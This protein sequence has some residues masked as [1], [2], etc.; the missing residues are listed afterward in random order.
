MTADGEANDPVIENN[1]ARFVVG[2]TG[3][4]PLLHVTNT[5][6][7]GLTTLLRD[8]GLDVTAVA[9][10]E[11]EAGAIQLANASGVILENVAA[12]D[13]PA[14]WTD[15]LAGLVED[16]GTGLWMTGG[17]QGFGPGGWF[18]SAIDPLLP[19]SMELRQEHR[20][21][22]LAI[23][24]ALDRSGSMA[25]TVAGGKQKMDL[26]NLGTAQVLELLSPMDE[27]GV[28]AVDSSAHTIADLAP[29]ADKAKL[30]NDILRIESMGG[31][32]YVFQALQASAEMLADAKAGTRH[33]V[34]FADAA[35][36]EEPGAYVALLAQCR[37]ANI[38]C[39]V[40]GLGR[41]TDS[42]AAFLRDVAAKGGGRIFFTED[43]R[44]LPAL[45]AQDTFAVARSAFVDEPTPL[46]ATAALAPLLGASAPP[47]GPPDAG[48]FGLT[49]LRPEATPA[50]LTA[51]EFRAP[52]VATWSAGLGRAAAFTGEADGETTGSLRGWP[53]YGDLLASLARFTAG[54]D[55]AAAGPP[56]SL[57]RQRVT[58]GELNVELLLDP[59]APPP[60]A[61]VL[62]RVVVSRP[63]QPP[64]RL[65]VPLR[66]AEPDRL[67]A[68]VPLAAEDTAVAAIDFGDG[69][70]APLPPA[71]LLYDPEYAPADD[72]ARGPA[73]LA[74]LTRVTGG[75][76]R[77]DL[78]TL[79]DD[80]PAVP[81]TVPLAWPVW[82]LSAAVLLV[83]VLER[84]TG[85]LSAPG[86][87]RGGGGGGGG[88]GDTAGGGPV[89]PP[90]KPVTPAASAPPPPTAPTGIGSAF[91]AASRRG[92]DRL[93]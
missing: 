39:S 25:A 37:A 56:G 32:I 29:V 73:T 30:R 84:R 83:E 44:K 54:A 93:S 42:D 86:E 3:P 48:G 19:V 7:G 15:D 9:P 52:F 91:D 49:Y 88:G 14:G 80:L 27:M 38:T 63:G 21:L 28:I 43:A 55:E 17:R 71:R 23:V 47:P 4:R 90:A 57:A 18:G 92:R 74:A 76:R 6:G 81:R 79:W 60:Q 75:V 46:S 72:A 20:K 26:A 78:G 64:R 31:G 69:S 22:A 87:G 66:Y 89:A 65:R 77:A 62:A 1:R 51:D 24:V 12:A 59:T 16:T 67:V 68:T 33:I 50:I 70:A 61:E 85:W 82:L 2:V 5:P 41:D 58:D 34:L 35:D 53:A 11:L 40:I 8:A 13:V 45:F 36:A 10:D